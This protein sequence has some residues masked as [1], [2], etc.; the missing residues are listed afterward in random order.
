MLNNPSRVTA[1]LQF[2]LHVLKIFSNY[3]D[4]CPGFTTPPNT[5]HLGAER[6]YLLLHMDFDQGQGLFLLSASFVRSLHAPETNR[7]DT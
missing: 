4:T 5:V 3:P 1:N 7:V 6:L 2:M